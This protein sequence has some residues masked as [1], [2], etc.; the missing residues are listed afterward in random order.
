MEREVARELS[1]A[2][3]SDGLPF[4]RSEARGK[5]LTGG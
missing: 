1:G 2:V 3:E 4:Y 5:R